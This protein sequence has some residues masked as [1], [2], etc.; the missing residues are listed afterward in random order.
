M[1][2]ISVVRPKRSPWALGLLATLLLCSPA[3][4]ADDPGPGERTRRVPPE[5]VG[6]WCPTGGCETRGGGPWHSAG[7][8]TA[9][10]AV[11]LLARRR[12]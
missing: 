1:P 5:M 12:G 2:P 9:L 10:G 8:A 6:A 4:A 7:F 3:L 11:L